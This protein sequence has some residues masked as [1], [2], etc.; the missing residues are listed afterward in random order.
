VRDH[1]RFDMGLMFSELF[2]CLVIYR[3]G[4][5]ARAG[6]SGR[7]V[8]FVTQYDVE[9]YQRL[10]DLIGKRLPEVSEAIDVNYVE[11]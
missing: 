9:A 1:G 4:R 7:S 5:T 2:T 11:K 10:E 3:V 6:K 8:A